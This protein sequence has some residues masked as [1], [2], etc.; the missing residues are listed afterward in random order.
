MVKTSKKKAR[1]GRRLLRGAVSVAFL[2]A[3]LTLMVMFLLFR[4]RINPDTVR[5]IMRLITFSREESPVSDEVKF[6]PE[7]KN[8]YGFY[9]G[10]L[11]IITK[12][13]LVLYN[14]SGIETFSRVLFWE[15]PALITSGGRVAAYE[16]GGGLLISDG[17]D[18]LFE[19][20]G[21]VLGA[22]FNSRQWI[23]VITRDSGY[24]GIVTAYDNKYKPRYAWNSASRYILD[25]ALSPSGKNLAI[26]AA[27]QDGES[28]VS[29]ITLHDIS[30]EDPEHEIA[31]RD[32]LVLSVIYPDNNHVCAILED[33]VEFYGSDGEKLSSYSAGEGIFLEFAHSFDFLLVH[34]KRSESALISE[35]IALDYEGNRI[36]GLPVSGEI[37]AISAQGEF[38]SVL[39]GSVLEIYNSMCEKIDSYGECA[40]VQTIAQQ[41]NG[42]VFLLDKN[43]ARLYSPGK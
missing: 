6:D 43:S 16:R 21:N 32:R 34:I 2:L 33:G 40:A 7:Q 24:R 14:S 30:K 39:S 17:K 5:G 1:R 35:L 12:E 22:K 4:D 27:S 8:L 11:A 10:R 13:R 26:A 41:S 28:L 25:A 18:I 38:F 19:L 3:V 29:Y 23:A 37:R 15:N 20:E 31:I 9:D 36:S 42:S